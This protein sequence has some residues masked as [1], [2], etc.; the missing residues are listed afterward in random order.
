MID[1]YETRIIPDKK[2]EGL[3]TISLYDKAGDEVSLP[4]V[5]RHRAK[6]L[7]ELIKSIENP[8]KI[9]KKENE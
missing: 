1:S 3:Y 7:S 8:P 6:S 5:V 2:I 9:F 4:E